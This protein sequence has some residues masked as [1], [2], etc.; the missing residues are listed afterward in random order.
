M[1]GGVGSR[2][3]ETWSRRGHGGKTDRQGTGLLGTRGAWDEPHRAQ[4]HG[5]PRGGGGGAWGKKS[6]RLEW[7]TGVARGKKLGYRR[8][9]VRGLQGTGRVEWM[10]GIGYG[11]C[12]GQ[13]VGTAG[14]GYEGCSGQ[15]KGVVGMGYWCCTGQE[16]G[17]TGMGC[18]SCR[19]QEEGKAGMGYHAG[20]WGM[21]KDEWT[22]GMGY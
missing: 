1:S 9:G 22:V 3:T 18:L 4:G 13:E 10:V 21:G 5:L 11:G 6:G 7:G 16:E 20:A 2:G 12:R 14:M 8:N 19:R 17:I 15:V